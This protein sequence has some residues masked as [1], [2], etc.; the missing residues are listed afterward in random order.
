MLMPVT[1]APC[2][3]AA[4]STCSAAARRR[5]AASSAGRR[6]APGWMPSQR[7]RCSSPPSA[8]RCVSGSTTAAP[9]RHQRPRG[10]AWPQH[11]PSQGETRGARVNVSHQNGASPGRRF[12]SFRL[13]KNACNDTCLHSMRLL[14]R[15][16]GAISPPCRARAAPQ[17]LRRRGEQ[18][19]AVA[20]LPQT[21]SQR[22]PRRRRTCGSAR[23]A[24]DAQCAL[25]VCGRQEPR[26]SEPWE[27]PLQRKLHAPATGTC[28]GAPP[29]AVTRTS[30][31]PARGTAKR[32]AARVSAF[33]QLAT[34]FYDGPLQTQR[35]RTSSRLS[36][37]MGLALHVSEA[38]Q[39][40]HVTAS[41]RC[42]GAACQP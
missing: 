15:G 29:S 33:A 10:A 6:R 37:G 23:G 13:G 27:P 11:K 39:S 21:R 28:C 12:F 38:P 41:S 30:W 36:H 34:P 18:S 32:H 3:P 4:R 8:Q 16:V 2:C 7:S 24:A 17:R 20:P 31:Q 42:L 14:R 26:E 35:E 9:A 22:Q 25:G 1:L 19:P 5:T 40:R